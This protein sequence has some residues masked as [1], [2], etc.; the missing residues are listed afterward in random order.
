[1]PLCL[2]VGACVC[3][4]AATAAIIASISLAAPS[5]NTYFYKTEKITDENHRQLYS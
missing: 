3:A 2:C 5:T 1:M 4:A